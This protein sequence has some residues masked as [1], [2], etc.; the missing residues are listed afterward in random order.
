MIVF[1]FRGRRFVVDVNVFCDWLERQIVRLQNIHYG[2]PLARQ[3][4]DLLNDIVL[5]EYRRSQL[6][7]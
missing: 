7:K 6:G 1:V 4:Q 5:A 3:L 2:H